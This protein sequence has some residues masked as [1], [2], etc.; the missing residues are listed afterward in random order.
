[1]GIQANPS[2]VA[3]YGQ[4][5]KRSIQE[6]EP[7]TGGEK[8]PAPRCTAFDFETTRT[9]GKRRAQRIYG[10]RRLNAPRPGTRIAETESVRQR[11]RN[12]RR[13]R[14]MATEASDVDCLWLGD[15]RSERGCLNAPAR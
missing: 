7:A 14:L 9:Y 1:M 3:K 6:A 4:H 8:I 5:G 11:A 13:S 15:A 2:E 10:A 12:Y